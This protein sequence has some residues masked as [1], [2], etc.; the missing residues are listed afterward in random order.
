MPKPTDAEIEDFK[1]SNPE[2]LQTFDV[3]GVELFSTG[4]WNGDPYDTGDL[5]E[6][7]R[8][9][10]E[11]GS[12]IK[13]Y[14]K[15][16]HSKDQA[17]LKSGD[18]PAAGWIENVR[19]EGNL[20]VADI[21]SVP[22]R[23]YQ[24]LKAKAYRRRSAEVLCNVKI[25]GKAYKYALKACA[26]LGGEMPAVHTLN[27][28][29]A[30]Y[31]TNGEA[32]AFNDAGAEL[33]AYDITS[34]EI[35]PMATAPDAKDLRITALEE[36]VAGLRDG[37]L[38]EFAAENTALKAANVKLTGERDSAVSRAD[39]A[40]ASVRE[41]AEKAETAE[42]NAKIDGLISKKKIAPAQRES[43][44][45]MLKGAKAQAEKKFSVGGKEQSLDAIV[46]E[47]FDKA[48]D[49]DINVDSGTELGKE[50]N[51]SKASR[52]KEYSAKNKVSYEEALIEVDKQDAKAAKA[53]V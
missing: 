39:T 24:L 13:P 10:T 9:H 17:L 53:S 20:L 34:Q 27:D 46:R 48:P 19:R 4:T 44:F 32:L 18:L 11:V 26:F 42:I 38:K 29:L 22:K 31:A 45:A 37:K 23:I 1:K 5:D 43:V 33:R 2:E 35:D 7:V 41:H 25:G 15:L 47:F 21:K 30:L 14:M 51:V 12:Q 3:L 52:A 36:E 28:V 49:L 40:E 16:G 50:T 6:M 8:A